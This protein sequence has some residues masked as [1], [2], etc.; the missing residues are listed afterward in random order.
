VGATRVGGEP[1]AGRLAAGPGRDRAKALSVLAANTAA[2][3]VCFAVWMMYGVLVTFLVD[4][5]VF[6]FTKAQIGWLIGIPVLTGSL[7]RLPAGML[8]DRYGGRPVFAGVMLLAA[9]A[10]YL[11]SF[12]NDFWGF[13]LGGLGFGLAG[14]SFAVGIAYTSVWFPAQQQ[15][16]ALGV[17]GIGNTGAA[18][19][20]IV[21][22]QL[23]RLLTHDGTELE[24]W[25]MLPQ[26][27]AVALV[28]MTVVF[29]LLTFPKKPDDPIQR[30]LHQRLEPLGSVRVWR[31]GLY[32]FLLFGGFVALAQWLIP[33]YVNVYTLSVVTAG[34]LSAVFSL[35][36]GLF[37]A[38]GGWLADRF[39]A[40][41]VMY[42]VLGGATAVC[43]LLAVPRMD[44]Q[45]PGQGVMAAR[46][47]TVTAVTEEAV[48]VDGTRYPLRRLEPGNPRQRG[49]LVLPTAASWQE[50]VVRPGDVV[51]KRALLARGVTRI[52]FQANIW[53]FTGLIFVLAAVMG[54]GM[55][56]VFKHIPTY[57][58]RDVGTVGGIVGVIGGLGGFIGPILFGYLL[59][60][61]GIW[62]T[63][64]MFLFLLSLICLVWMHAVVRRMLNVRAP[65]V[66]GQMDEKG[67]PVP[68]SL[69]V[70]C[71]VHAVEATVRVFVTPGSDSSPRL[72]ACS[73]RPGEGP[74][75]CEGRCVVTAGEE[76]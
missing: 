70:L 25:R 9:L 64:W 28:A 42:R 58:P 2:F 5:Q 51:P 12:A 48:E 52:Y 39:G 11:T 15:G 45:S 55:A 10:A 72:A 46:G 44:I 60:G 27:Y 26:I 67:T 7:F 63:N 54:I 4:Q 66:A 34:L 31:F 41:T 3:M 1:G 21:S 38:L 65:E 71:P 32:Y 40:R 56:A 23:L 74:P 59:Q 36:S 68:V 69:R 43:L 24:R 17:F 18:L 14:A 13:I 75:A 30:T 57:F 29:W 19:T 50:P 62:T 33:Y 6:A 22:P 53:V 16:T 49:T 47:G 73:L 8:T 37:R 76:D 61:T 35:P 20:A